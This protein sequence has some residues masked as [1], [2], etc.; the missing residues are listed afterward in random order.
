MEKVMLSVPLVV[1]K[2][3]KINYWADRINVTI[4][5]DQELLNAE[6]AKVKEMFDIPK[7]TG[8]LAPLLI[9]TKLLQ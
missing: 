6:H 3:K 1:E 8:K 5:M 4:V 9:Q 7:V 2:A